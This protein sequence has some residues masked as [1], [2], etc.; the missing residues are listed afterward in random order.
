MPLSRTMRYT[1]KTIAVSLTCAAALSC[2]QKDEAPAARTSVVV[3]SEL[4]PPTIPATKSAKPAT[5]SAQ[6]KIV[7][8]IIDEKRLEPYLHRESEGRVPLVLSSELL[9]SDLR[10]EKFGKPVVISPQENIDGPHIRFTVF[11]CNP[12]N[13]KGYCN[14]VFEYQVEGVTGATGAFIRESGEAH[15]E[16]FG[17][18]E[19]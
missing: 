14:I 18:Y 19:K 17:V 5:L 2:S 3:P 16:K 1:S 10:L 8:L 9:E 4:S 6:N 12:P 13:D 7:Q 11:E 15:L